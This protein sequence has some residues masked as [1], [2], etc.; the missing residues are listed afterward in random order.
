MDIQ[1]VFERLTKV[2]IDQ[3]GEKQSENAIDPEFWGNSIRF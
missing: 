2:D 3:E 1:H